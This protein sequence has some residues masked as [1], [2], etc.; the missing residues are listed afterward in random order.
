MNRK[1]KLHLSPNATQW[2]I[3]RNW[4]KIHTKQEN[5]WKHNWF[6]K[7]KKRQLWTRKGKTNPS[8]AKGDGCD[9]QKRGNIQCRYETSLPDRKWSKAEHK[10]VY[11]KRWLQWVRTAS[12]VA[13][14][15]IQS[16]TRYMSTNGC[17]EDQRHRMPNLM[18]SR[19]RELA[20]Y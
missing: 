12:F 11:Y 15:W 1:K 17:S 9:V 10:E 18:H 5:S 3:A 13:R 19:I 2:H 7:N 4:T 14:H 6:K 20:L 16:G 8:D